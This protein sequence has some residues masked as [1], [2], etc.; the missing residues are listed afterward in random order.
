MTLKFKQY[1]PGSLALKLV[2]AASIFLAQ[3]GCAQTTPTGTLMPTNTFAPTETPEPTV[4]PVTATMCPPA[5]T[6]YAPDWQI[7]CNSTYEFALQYP[8]YSTLT[9]TNPESAHI[10][11]PYTEGTNLQ[12]KYLEISAHQTTDPC[13]S[14]LAIG[15]APESLQTQTVSF[16]G[17]EFLEESASEGA[18]GNFYQWVAYSTTRQDICVS[19]GFVLHSTNPDNY[20]TPPPLFDQATEAAV[21][22]DIMSTFVWLKP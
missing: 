17:I 9:V 3:S 14:P 1:L 15:F 12:E 7:Y 18:A 2:F 10:D 5:V 16:N 22:D 6:P 13:T 4:T 11:L 21:F 20:S 19:L 8:P